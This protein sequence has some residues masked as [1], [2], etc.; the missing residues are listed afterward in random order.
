MRCPS[1]P[2]STG[3]FAEGYGP[4]SWGSQ[5]WLRRENL[6]AQPTRTGGAAKALPVALDRVSHCTV[7]F[8]CASPLCRA[9]SGALSTLSSLQG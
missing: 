6:K 7:R 8:P 9:R 3:S 2:C 4:E 5:G 1:L